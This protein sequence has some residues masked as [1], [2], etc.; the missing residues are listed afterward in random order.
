[1][2]LIVLARSRALSSAKAISIGLR[3]GLY[4]GRN[5][6]QAPLAR[7][8]ASAAALFMGGQVVQ[9]DDIARVKG[10]SELGSDALDIISALRRR[11]T[12]GFPER[13]LE[14]FEFLVGEAR[15]INRWRPLYLPSHIPAPAPQGVRAQA[16]LRSHWLRPLV[17][18]GH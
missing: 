15:D 16:P 8:A 17:G 4:G 11:S 10:R 13:A 9:D 18:A 3:S 7:M 6:S 2:V 12:D 14:H 5:K 1:M